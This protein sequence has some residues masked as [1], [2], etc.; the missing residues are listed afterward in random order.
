MQN[1]NGGNWFPTV[2]ETRG[3]L[4]PSRRDVFAMAALAGILTAGEKDPIVATKYAVECAQALVFELELAE[5][6]E[7]VDEKLEEGKKALEEAGR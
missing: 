2:L 4:G 5:T 3:T 7:L 6:K 1:R